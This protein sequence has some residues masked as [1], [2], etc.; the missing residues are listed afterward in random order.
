MRLQ[1]RTISHSSFSSNQSIFNGNQELPAY[2]GPSPPAPTYQPTEPRTPTY[3]P[4]AAPAAQT[5]QP[6][7]PPASTY[8]PTAPPAYTYD[9]NTIVT[10]SKHY[11]TLQSASQFEV[12]QLLS[13]SSITDISDDDFHRLVSLPDRAERS[14]YIGFMK[15]KW[16]LFGYDS[17]TFVQLRGFLATI[18]VEEQWQY[19]QGIEDEWIAHKDPTRQRRV[20]S[21]EFD[22]E[23]GKVGRA[24]SARRLFPLTCAIKSLTLCLLGLGIIYLCSWIRERNQS[25]EYAAVRDGDNGSATAALFALSASSVVPPVPSW[26]P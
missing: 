7:A 1:K 16:D 17:M 4:L 20:R 15:A 14:A 9:A 10:D 8:Q 2:P 11:L 18:T 25:Q 3:Q 13:E 19:L 6:T 12:I 24:P 5:C 26:I 21:Q 23:S 22:E